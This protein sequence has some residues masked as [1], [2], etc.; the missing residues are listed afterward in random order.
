MNNKKRLVFFGGGDFG[1][2]IFRKL[3]SS[4]YKPFLL[5]TTP[6]KPAGRGLKIKKSEIEELAREQGISVLTPEKFNEEF[7]KELEKLHPDVG[8]IA[9][10]GKIIPGSALNIL[11]FG[12][13][14]VHPSLLPKYRGASPIQTTILNSD[15]Q[16]GTTI[17]LTDAEIDQGPIIASEKIKMKNEKVTYKELEKQ[18]AELG[19]EL[20]I[21]TLPDFLAGKIKPQ[22]Q[23]H[24]EATFTKIIKKEDGHLNFQE[25]AE[26]V[27][28]KI[29]AFDPWPGTYTYIDSTR[30][31][32]ILK[33]GVAKENTLSEQEKSLAPSTLFSKDNQLFVRC[34]EGALELFELQLGGRK[35]LKAVDFI[36]GYQRFLNK[37]L[38]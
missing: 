19:A 10:Y 25:P 31:L 24:G 34:K 4:P 14:N 30:F 18:L 13:L 2:V 15:I 28:R 3:L 16:T 26:I 21:K 33:A 35:P 5:I 29:R 23:N 6:T 37:Q 11:K 27:E 1:K 38:S 12:V 36:R 20:L 32:K 17:I 9:S 8:V 7:A 22:A